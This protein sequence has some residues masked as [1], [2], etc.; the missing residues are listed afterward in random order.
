MHYA[1]PCVGGGLGRRKRSLWHLSSEIHLFLLTLW[2][3]VSWL[4]QS[5]VKS[6][7]A[8]AIKSEGMADSVPR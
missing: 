5:V 2:L 8:L 4:Q 1:G 7:E 3:A 6:E